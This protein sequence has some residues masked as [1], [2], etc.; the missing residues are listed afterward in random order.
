MGQMTEAQ[1]L[2]SEIERVTPV[3]ATLY[4]KDTTFFGQVEKRPVEVI[5][6]RDMRIVLDLKPGGK[7]RQWNS[8]GGDMGRGGGPT[9]DKAVINTVDLEHVIEWTTRSQWVTDDKRKAVINNFRD[10]LAKSMG[11]FR[12]N[13]DKLASRGDGN[14]VLGTIT[15]WTQN[16]PVG[17]DTLTFTTDGFGAHLIRLG[18]DVQTW[19][20]DFSGR[21]DGNVALEVKYVDIPNKTIRVV[22]GTQAAVVAGD[23]IVFDGAQGTP[24]TSL[25]GIQ[26]H[27]N[28]ASVGS[29]LGFDRSTTPEI[30]SN[31]VDGNNQALSHPQPRL[32]LNK[33]GDRL[34][35]ENRGQ[36]TQAWTHPAQQS[37]YEE[38]GYGNVQIF[39]QAKEE[40]LD[41]YFS[42]NMRLAGAP[43][44]V[45]YNW[46]RTRIDFIDMDVWGR[47]ELHKAGFYE[48]EGRKIFEIRSA[49]GGLNASCI[50]YLVSSFNLFVK[51]P[52]A[53]AYIKSLLVPS[54]Y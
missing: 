20:N 49:D 3:V 22:T 39:K 43:L 7:T 52:A 10:L 12:S 48:V 21:R 25:L 35:L 18:C 16:T 46:D 53:S 42:D 11:M 5:S 34:G 54:G 38:M 13:T 31:S 4:E 14:G 8:D 40:A 17:F 47:A 32:A 26:Y 28:D 9:Y 30:R 36:K 33:I 6:G 41:L 1:V 44:K 24:P 45:S 51:N 19:A 15:T 37:A 29:W 50:I 23:F 27:N 2:A